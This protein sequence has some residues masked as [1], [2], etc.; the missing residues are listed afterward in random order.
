MLPKKSG[1]EY[2]SWIVFSILG[3]DIMSQSK[4]NEK[5]DFAYCVNL[6]N[7]VQHIQIMLA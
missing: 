3:F 5:V 2:G 1:K 4:W 6:I 7:S